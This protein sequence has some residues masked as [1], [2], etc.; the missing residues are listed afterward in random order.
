MEETS[1]FDIKDLET[2]DKS[3]HV[4]R[5][6]HESRS[7]FC[8][9]LEVRYSGRIF[10]AKTL[11]PEYRGSQPHKQLLTKEYEI[12]SSLYHPSIIQ[13]FGIVEIEGEGPALL[14]EY[15]Y[16]VT[17]NDYL[18]ERKRDAV[19]TRLI[20]E[21]I[22]A[23]V[24]YCHKR[25]VIHRDLKPSNIIVYPQGPVVKIIDFNLSHSPAYTAPPLPG[26]TIGFS[27]P[28]EFASNAA[29]AP[30][31]DIWSIGKLMEMILPKGDR[32][33]LR[34][35]EKCLDPLP[36]NRPSSASLI[37]IMLDEKRG[38]SMRIFAI[39]AIL[40]ILIVA[41][42]IFIFLNRPESG[43]SAIADFPP[44][45][46]NNTAIS[47]RNDTIAEADDK[48]KVEEKG[49]VKA[50]VVAEV[51]N[52]KDT[53]AIV[54]SKATEMAALRFKEQLA[55]LDTAT[56]QHTFAL[57]KA[58]HWRWKANQDMEVWLKQQSLSVKERSRLRTISGLAIKDFEE[59]HNSELKKAFH[60]AA[61]NR[62]VSSAL[63]VVTQEEN[64]IGGVNYIVKELDED[65]EW[66]TYIKRKD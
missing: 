44:M 61:Y 33:W 47:L 27:A 5:V 2:Y 19:K 60:D 59:N 7:G 6:V 4:V 54:K 37:P 65:G 35:V 13:T 21:Q 43:N 20:L 22:C 16:G 28:E 64:Y 34:V 51:I 40:S 3:Y 38:V 25:G 30:S 18:T 48:V 36:E 11:K 9:I 23:A 56:H 15:A 49:N 26:G 42:A 29:A 58:G 53:V 52:Q 31:S 32:A 45:I 17:L 46:D 62:N 14:L 8:R 12:L 50:A 41:A 63:E 24:D 57:A 55:I 10:I 39:A 66:R 1:G